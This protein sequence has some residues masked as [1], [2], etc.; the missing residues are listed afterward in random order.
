[1]NQT[2]QLSRSRTQ[3][4]NWVGRRGV[5]PI[6]E[7]LRIKVVYLFCTVA[8]LVRNAPLPDNPLEL[9]PVFM[10]Q[11]PLHSITNC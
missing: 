6:N 9:V 8:A 11:L 2:P 4:Y 10:V 3:M 5:L 7:F 1:M